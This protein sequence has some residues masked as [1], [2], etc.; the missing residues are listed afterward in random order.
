MRILKKNYI[1]L[2]ER[3]WNE[4]IIIWK[5]IWWAFP[6]LHQRKPTP[7]S[8]FKLSL[9]SEVNT[10]MKSERPSNSLSLIPSSIHEGKEA[11]RNIHLF[12][13]WVRWF[14]CI[15]SFS[16]QPYVPTVTWIWKMMNRD[17]RLNNFSSVHTL[18]IAVEPAE[19]ENFAFIHNAFSI[20]SIKYQS[21]AKCNLVVQSPGG[22]EWREIFIHTAECYCAQV[23]SRPVF[24]LTAYSFHIKEE[25]GGESVDNSWSRHSVC[26]AVLPCQKAIDKS[27]ETLLIKTQ[28]FF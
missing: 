16:Q 28:L 18:K 5:E 9:H 24:F 4:L 15:I 13:D 19:K 1:K 25:N 17:I 10:P 2:I 12:G 21:I 27:K 7:F 22:E 14:V 26:T 23:Q 8:F 11:T 6:C 3:V 20:N